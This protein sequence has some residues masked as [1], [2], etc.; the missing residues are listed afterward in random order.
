MKG[1][2]K[3]MDDRSHRKNLSRKLEKNVCN[4][5]EDRLIYCYEYDII[6]FFIK[7]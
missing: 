2:K 5:I 7:Y 1:K 3:Q 6:I 4:V